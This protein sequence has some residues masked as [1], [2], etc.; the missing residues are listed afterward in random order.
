MAYWPS[1]KPLKDLALIPVFPPLWP[2]SEEHW[3]MGQT[4][5]RG[6]VQTKLRE[7]R[8]S[9]A[10][11]RGNHKMAKNDEADL[12]LSSS[13]TSHEDSRTLPLPKSAT[14]PWP[15]CFLGVTIRTINKQNDRSKKRL[16][17][18]VIRSPQTIQTF[19]PFRFCLF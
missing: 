19:C 14:H 1:S 4:S 9:A 15:S 11:R 3:K 8:C 5:P 7:N 12:L 2:H 6:I 10:L 18:F 16:T 13:T 17:R